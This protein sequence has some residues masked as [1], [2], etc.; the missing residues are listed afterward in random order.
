MKKKTKQPLKIKSKKSQNHSVQK[1]K[2]K[3]R[4]LFNKKSKLKKKRKK[5]IKKYRGKVKKRF[6]KKAKIKS[7][8]KSN[9]KTRAFVSGLLRL[10]AKLKSLVRFNFN[11]DQSLQNFFNGISNKVSGIKKVIIEEREK[12]KHLKIKQIENEKKKAQKKLI[13]EVELALKSKKNELK[14]E[15][16]LE[17]ER[18][19]DL[20]KFIRLEQAEL[21]KE[22]AE[23][24]RKFLEQIKLEK[25]IDQF[26]KREELEIKSL[27]KYV[28]S[29]QRE[30]YEEVQQRIDRIKEKY[31]ALRE[32]K[33]NEA[34]RERVANLGIEI[35][36]TDD[37][38]TLLEKERIYSEERQKIEY[39]LESFFR[40]AHSLT[41][42]LNKR[43]IPK[44]LSILRCIDKR[45]ETGEIYI[46]WDDSPD[47]EWLILI[48]IKNNS[49][50]EGIIIEDK[51]NSEK[52]MT[53]EFQPKE[54]FKASDVMVDAL[55][56]LLDAERNK[57]KVN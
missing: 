23:K 4:K 34:I 1:S 15:Q 22:R 27:E 44:Y 40:S 51:T 45:F 7:V 48:Y 6:K 37:K 38:G 19:I 53:Y 41:F 20:Q 49:P 47:E 5:T 50:D 31:K 2:N 12:Q 16:K 39:A 28:L 30:S 9:Q 10:N 52:N 56:K 55:T 42:Q 29:Q 17:R 32:Q 57:R 11:L 36:D 21:R 14:E 24:Q 18:K 33:I 13:E 25:K 8:K 54:I 35:E 46:K 43:Y 3:K 26:R